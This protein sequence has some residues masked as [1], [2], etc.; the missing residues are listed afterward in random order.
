MVGVFF[1]AP[2]FLFSRT[3]AGALLLLFSFWTVASA[4]QTF[5]VSPVADGVSSRRLR[6]FFHDDFRS[7]CLVILFPSLSA[8][9]DVIIIVLF[10]LRRSSRGNR[11]PNFA[12]LVK[13]PG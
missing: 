5:F 8:V 12:R 9:S 2:H 13:R 10:P 3:S 11:P 1:F 7:I 6:V 4:A